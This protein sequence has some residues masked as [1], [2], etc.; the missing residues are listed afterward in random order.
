[1]KQILFLSALFAISGIL[2]VTSCKHIYT[3][4]LTEHTVTDDC[5]PDTVY[6]TN[7]VLPIIISNCTEAGCH[8]GETTEEDAKPL[9]NYDEIMNSEW[10]DPFDP[11]S[12]KLIEVLTETGDDRMPQEPNDPLTAAQIETLS[13]WI[14]QGARNNECSGGCDTTNVSYSGTVAITMETYCTGCH[15]GTA[16]SGDIALTNYSEVAAIAENGGLMGT[17]NGEYGWVA[18]PYGG[19]MLPDCK[20]DEI[21][22]W[23]ENGYPND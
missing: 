11:Q 1:M 16:P 22:I 21:R 13:A 14:A 4:D 10:V 19:S 12:S 15:S 20:I 2:S 18:M 3:P 5:D 6:F 8:N 17:I 23:V 7:D 9:T